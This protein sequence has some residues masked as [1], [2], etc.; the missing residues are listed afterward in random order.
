MTVKIKKDGDLLDVIEDA[1]KSSGVNAEKWARKHRGQIREL[2]QDEAIEAAQRVFDRYYTPKP[3]PE[4]I[5]MVASVI[6]AT[7]RQVTEFWSKQ[8]DLFG[9][10]G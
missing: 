7:T 5:A 3:T 4:G 2:T 6:T 10:T 8:L 1:R 9:A